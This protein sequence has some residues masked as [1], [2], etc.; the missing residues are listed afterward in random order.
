MD[1]IDFRLEVDAEDVQAN[2]EYSGYEIKHLSVDHEKKQI[3]TAYYSYSWHC[4]D[5]CCSDTCDGD[6]YAG[7]LSE[8]VKERILKELPGYTFGY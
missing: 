7:H 5:G 2:E 4:G 3:L 6:C 8:W 1:S